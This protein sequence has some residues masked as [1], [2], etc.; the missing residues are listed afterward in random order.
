MLILFKTRLS[1]QRFH[2]LPD[3]SEL[4]LLYSIK[5]YIGITTWVFLALST[6]ELFVSFMESVNGVQFLNIKFLLLLFAAAPAPA[7]FATDI[8]P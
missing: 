7:V 5:L 2:K 8:V 6:C 4:L 3:F 1:L